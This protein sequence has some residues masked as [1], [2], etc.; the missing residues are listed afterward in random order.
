MFSNMYLKQLN[1][2]LLKTADRL[3]LFDH[4]TTSIKNLLI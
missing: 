4:V 3:N 1:V 2:T